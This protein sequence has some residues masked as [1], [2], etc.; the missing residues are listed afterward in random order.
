MPLSVLLRQH[1]I[2]LGSSTEVLA[3][4]SATLDAFPVACFVIDTQHRVIHWN[5]ASETLTGVAAQ[6]IVGTSA[7][8]QV[9]YASHRMVMADLIVSGAADQEV[10]ALYHGKFRPSATLP[11]TYEAE[12]YFPQ[13]GDGGRWLYFTAAP[14]YDASGTLIGAIETLQDITERR[15]AEEALRA[16]EER[17]K[18]LS[19][20][21][22]LTQLFNFR[23]FHEQLG[24]E[25]DRAARYGHPLSL[26]I[27]DVDH[28][29]QVNDRYGHLEG[30]RVLRLVA[31]EI[32]AWKRRPDAAFRYG[33]DEF[34]VLLP[35]TDQ[36][37]AHAAAKR[38]A[39][40]WSRLPTEAAAGST[41]GCTLS[42]GLAQYRAGDS[43]QELIQRA[44][45]AAY[46]AK[47]SG[48]NCIA[49][50]R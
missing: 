4:L 41:L 36:S 8:G 17:F 27:I 11:G 32:T 48:R 45:G 3:I 46:M 50:G 37:E 33:G 26:I 7:Q 34:A 24:I 16:S 30:D 15:R 12:D 44:D 6:S 38:L 42:I 20:T 13:F 31:D 10:D 29:K 39:E 14:L 47:R 49:S 22:Q 28:F 35:E 2:A 9:F 21:D 43:P 40:R 25:I 5:R 23:H 1:S 19:R 18:L